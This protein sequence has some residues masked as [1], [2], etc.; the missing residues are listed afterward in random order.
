MFN[1]GL[2][3][4]KKKKIKNALGVCFCVSFSGPFWTDPFEDIGVRMEP[5]SNSSR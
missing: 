2:Q 4:K 1:L 3:K 5:R